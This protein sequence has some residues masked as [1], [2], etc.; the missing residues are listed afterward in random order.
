[1]EPP[2]KLMKT[3][4]LPLFPYGHMIRME[5]KA[6]FSGAVVPICAF[7]PS[8]DWACGLCHGNP[9]PNHRDKSRSKASR[10]VMATLERGRAPYVSGQAARGTVCEILR[11]TART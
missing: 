2:N 10:Q 6:V 11:S 9:D 8:N 1:M 7:S 4:D 5:L 3:H